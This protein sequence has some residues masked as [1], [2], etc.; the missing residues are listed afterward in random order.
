MSLAWKRN[1][2]V[3]PFEVVAGDTTQYTVHL[4]ESNDID[5]SLVKTAIEECIEKSVSLLAENINEKSMYYLCEWD[6]VCSMLTIVVTDATKEIDSP[7][8]VKCSFVALDDK[9][10]KLQDREDSKW[11]VLVE[12]YSENVRNWIRDYL[13]TCS[14]FMSYSLVAAFH[15]E[16]RES[17]ELL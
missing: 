13:T 2:E 11:E 6:P 15:S 1:R 10:L 3:N 14:G 4:S 16:S 9:F 8:V 17:S 5:D 7:N 12:K